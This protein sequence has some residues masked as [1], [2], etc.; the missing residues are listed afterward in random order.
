LAMSAMLARVRW[1][2]GAMLVLALS[3]SSPVLAGSQ[4]RVIRLALVNIADDIVRPL[5][6]A[7]R[8]KTGMTAEIVYMGSDPFSVAEA[9]EADL[10]ISHYGHPGVEP[11][12]TQ[13]R[14]KWPHPV[15]ANQMAL[16]GPKDDPAQIRGM[17]NAAD[18][19]AR[20]AKT[21]STFVVNA[22]HGARYLESILWQ[23]A[24]IDQ[25]GEW[26]IDR[27]TAGKAAMEL[28]TRQSAYVLWGFA[29]YLRFKQR[30]GTDLEPLVVGDPLF[31]RIMVSIVVNAEGNAAEDASAFERYLLSP[32]A[33]S[34]IR[35]FRYPGFQQ[36]MWWPAGRHNG[37]ED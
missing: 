11:F 23:N 31:Q 30:S 25:F 32:E 24:G 3:T 17:T 16:F 10:V 15:F 35:A 9:G 5:L 20:I 4:P 27:N 21:R 26:H 13:G 37:R 22:S 36:P 1:W 19:L 6:P 12:V 28:A 33:Q 34:R 29:P 18:A 8:E 2:A 14:G 7:F